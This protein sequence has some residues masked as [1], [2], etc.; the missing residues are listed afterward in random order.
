M[1]GLAVDRRA[2]LDAVAGSV[3]DVRSELFP[4]DLYSEGSYVVDELG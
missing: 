3:D 4:V 2:K 1:S